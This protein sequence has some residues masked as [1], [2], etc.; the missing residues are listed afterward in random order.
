M[1]YSFE[2]GSVVAHYEVFVTARNTK[3]NF[4]MLCNGQR[5][6]LSF[7]LGIVNMGHTLLCVY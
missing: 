7:G 6:G 1:L 4:P 2:W 5:A 3:F